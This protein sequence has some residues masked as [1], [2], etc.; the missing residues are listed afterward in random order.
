M[1]RA[2]VGFGT[3]KR[4]PLDAS[5][6]A[7]GARL[8][9]FAGWEMPISYAGTVAEHNAV[10]SGAGVFDVSHLGKIRV[11]GDAAAILLDAALTNRMDNLE[12][13]R[14]R[15]TLM[16][17]ADSGGIVD[18]MIVYNVASTGDELLVV[19]NASN[20]DEVAA[21]LRAAAATLGS[22]VEIEQGD[23]AILA[24]QGPDARRILEGVIPNAP[25]LAYMHIGEADPFVIARSGYTGEHGYEIFAQP[26]DAPGLWKQILD[27]GAVPCGLAARDTLRLEM[28]YPLHGSDI[29]LTTLPSEAGLMWSLGK[30]KKDF[31]GKR[32]VDLATARKTLVGIRMTDR[33]IPRHGCAV[34]DAAGTKVGECTSGTFSPT[35]KIGIAMAY[36]TPGATS[37]GTSVIVDVRGKHGA[38][39]IVDPPFV[40]SSPKR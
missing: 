7:L 25:E 2:G 30:T 34:L 13:G 5:H 19:P 18:D 3:M 9:E 28:G 27:A 23:D 31:I 1:R 15:Y 21:R 35:L 29:D 38:G 8:A 33:S 4:S 22:D 36:V 14:A 26:G 32:A 6:K 11:R 17:D 40:D 20:V 39:S 12:A 10:R 37:L 24:L 16:L